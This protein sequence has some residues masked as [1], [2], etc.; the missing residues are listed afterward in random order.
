MKRNT[1]RPPTVPT[2]SSSSITMKISSDLKRR[3]IDQ[4]QGYGMTITE[5]FTMLVERDGGK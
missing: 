5:Y 4:A 1:G 3:V 2:G